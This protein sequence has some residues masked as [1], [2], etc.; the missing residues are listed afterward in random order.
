MT[1]ML[2]PFVQIEETVQFYLNNRAYE[3]KENNIEIIERPTNKDF[4]NAIAA[5]E[6]FD[7]VGNDIKW[8]SKGSK[9]IYNIE[10]GKFYNGTSEINESFTT[11]VLA[12]GLVRYENKNKAELFESLST[13]VENFMY[14]DFA[15]TYKKGGVTVDLFKL[16]ENLFISRFNKDTNLSK[17]FTATANEAVTYIKEE[18]TEDASNVVIEMLEGE[19]LE[20]AKKSEEI[21]KFEEMISFLK[22]QRGLLAEADKSIEEIKAADA[23]INSEIKIWEDKIEALNA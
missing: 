22:D 23:L 5:F 17:F 7:I 8:Y 16:D 1:N 20:L 12:S 6:S 21:S 15:T 10:E 11:Y 13:I 14:L 4:L 9:F 19:T 3:I 2:A 18:T